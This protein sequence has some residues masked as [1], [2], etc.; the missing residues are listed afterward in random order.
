MRWFALIALVVA[1]EAPESSG[2]VDAMLQDVAPQEADADLSDAGDVPDAADRPDGSLPDAADL[3]DADPP[4]PPRFPCDLFCVEC[5]GSQVLAD[6]A[7]WCDLQGNDALG[8][9]MRRGCTADVA[10]QCVAQT[11][12]A[13]ACQA[14]TTCTDPALREVA[15]DPAC[16]GAT[17]AG[18]AA[19]LAGATTCE[20]VAAC[21][22]RAHLVV[23]EAPEPLSRETLET[24]VVVTNSGGLPTAPLA[25]ELDDPTMPFQVVSDDCLGL[26]LAPGASCTLGVILTTL[27]AGEYRTQLLVT[28]DELALSIPLVADTRPVGAAD[29]E[30]EPALIDFGRVVGVAERF[31]E[32]HNRGA[33]QSGPVRAIVTER[34]DVFGFDGA[35][36]G[37]SLA[38]GEVCRLTVLAASRA[39]AGPV[40]GMAV[41]EADPGSAVRLTLRA[42]LVPE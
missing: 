17:F 39:A 10:A 20:A 23:Q 14:A 34:F 11:Q 16:H 38:P 3:P 22:P 25:A 35:C 42:L 5:G 2:L 41:V 19:C 26:P 21:L 1:C 18:E 15:C 30:I 29:L 37:R 36:L 40:E 6:C 4:A 7:A 13:A 28:A 27:D 24:R 32:V 33:A 9:C 31:V 12:C 8:Q